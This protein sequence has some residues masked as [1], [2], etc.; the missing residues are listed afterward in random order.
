MGSGFLRSTS[1]LLTPQ[2]ALAKPFKP[3]RNWGQAQTHP[4][5]E[6]KQTK[7]QLFATICKE[8]LTSTVFLSRAVLFSTRVLSQRLGFGL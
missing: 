8:S 1:A 7:V 4:R 6:E 3:R 5:S 2:V